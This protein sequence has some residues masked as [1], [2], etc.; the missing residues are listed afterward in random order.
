MKLAIMQPYFLPYIGYFQLIAAVDLFVV[1]DTIKYTKRGWINRNRLLKNGEAALFTLP[2]A[3]ASDALDVRERELAADFQPGHL[4]RQ[5]RGAY[6]KAPYFADT[7]PVVERLVDQSER[8]LFRFIHRAIV[9]VCDHLGITTE[10][11]PASAIAVEPGLQRDERI[12]AICRAVGAKAYY[13]AI[14][15]SELYAKDTFA[16]RGVDLR[17]VQARPFAYDQL[18]APFV[19][20]LSIVDVLM[21][22]PRDAVRQQVFGGYDLV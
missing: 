13:N 5:F 17:F 6:A 2:L 1:Y 10:I 16:A 3:K 14:G 9:E 12:L 19:P 15:G 7:M 22:N 20:W 4:L 21:F 18:G 8:N 11:R